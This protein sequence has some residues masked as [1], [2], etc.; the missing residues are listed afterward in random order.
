MERVSAQ[1]LAGGLPEL[2]AVPRPD[3]LPSALAGW[4][5][6]GF[7]AVLWLRWL[8]NGEFDTECVVLG[9]DPDGE[10]A[11]HS[12]C[13][14]GGTWYP[15]VDELTGSWRRLNEDPDDVLVCWC[16][17]TTT[18]V[19]GPDGAGDTFLRIVSGF[20]VPEVAALRVA[21]PS[22]GTYV[23]E[24]HPVTGALLVGTLGPEPLVLAALDADGAE[25]RGPT[26]E[27]V[28]DDLAASLP[29][30]PPGVHA[31]A[32][33]PCADHTSHVGEFRNTYT[34]GALLH[35]GVAASPEAALDLHLRDRPPIA[36]RLRYDRAVSRARAVTFHGRSADGVVHAVVTAE[37]VG[38]P[39]RWLVSFARACA[40]K[41]ER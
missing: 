25:L 36:A 17:D 18:A 33:V 3:G 30:D 10:W 6:A 5:G 31:D 23:V 32:L 7:G 26:G 39:D 38:G 9:C 15:C 12:S 4:E 24:P 16:D 34:P 20:A 19:T 2:R 40:E 11:A 27:V 13:G 41:A 14:A 35:P 21:S 22:V 1:I 37:Q 8:S 28:L 29:P